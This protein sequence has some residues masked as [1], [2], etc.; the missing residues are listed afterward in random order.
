MLLKSQLDA[1][2]SSANF[3]SLW[4]KNKQKLERKQAYFHFCDSEAD[5]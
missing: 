4:L 1:G 5:T 2:L 3:T